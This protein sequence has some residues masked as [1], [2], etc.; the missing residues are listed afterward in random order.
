MKK[1]KHVERVLEVEGLD[2]QIKEIK[3]GSVDADTP[4]VKVPD[5]KDIDFDLKPTVQ[6]PVIKGEAQVEVQKPDAQIEVD[7]PDVHIVNPEIDLAK[8]SR[9]R[10]SSSSSSSSDEEDEKKKDKDKKKKKKDKKEK[11]DKDKKEKK[12]GF[13]GLFGRKSRSPS[14]KKETK[15]KDKKKKDKK[16]GSKESTPDRRSTS[17]EGSVEVK[18]PLP[19]GEV[20]FPEERK[21][22]GFEVTLPHLKLPSLHTAVNPEGDAELEDVSLESPKG[23]L[24][25]EAKVKAKAPDPNLVIVT[26]EIVT[27]EGK[28]KES[29]LER[30]KKRGFFSL[31]RGEKKD[32]DNK[33]KSSID[34]E[35]SDK[36]DRSR[37]SLNVELE[38]DLPEEGKIDADVKLKADRKRKSSTGSETSDPEKEKKHRTGF[39][40]HFPKFGGK[41]KGE[42]ETEGPK[43]GF[44]VEDLE[45]VEVKAPKV[46]TEKKRKSSVSSDTS[47]TEKEKK[48][49]GFDIHLPKAPKITLPKFGGKGEG[50]V[51]IDVDEPEVEVEV[52]KKRKSSVSSDTSDTDKEKKRKGF[53][54][55][56]PKVSL[57]KFGGK[58]K[59]EGDVEGPKEGY[60]VE[61]L[62]AVEVAAPKVKAEKQRKSSTSSET[63][64]TDKEGKRRGFDLHLPKAPKLE[65]PKFGGKGSVD[66]E[67][68]VDADKPKEGFVVEDL[69]S[70][71]VKAPKVEK[72]RTTSTSS[73]T[74]DTDKEGKRR[75]FDI[76]LPKVSLPKF[77]G[78]GKVEAE[79]DEPE[80]EVEVEKKRKSS[81]SS[82]TSDTDKEK[83]KGFDIHLPNVH[84]PK[85]GGK[86]K[87]E[88]DI[89]GPKE[90]FVIEDLEAVEVKAPKVKADRK[91]SVSSDTSDTDRE[92]RKGFDLHLPKAPKINL[93]KFGGK[94]KVEGDI[95]VD[96]DVP[97]VEVEVEKKRKSS[98]SS[99]TGDTDK[100]KKRKGFDIHLPKVSL[101]KF[102]GKAKVDGEVD[103]PSEGFVVEDLESIEVKKPK[104]KRK[105]STGSDPDK[106]EVELEAPSVSVEKKS[107]SLDRKTPKKK[108]FGGFTFG[109]KTP[110]VKRKSSVSSTS[111]DEGKTPKGPKEGF[112]IEDVVAV[113]GS[114]GKKHK[115]KKPELDVEVEGP[116]LSVESKSSSLDKKS[117][118]TKKK[119]FGGFS[120]GR[121]K[122][123]S[124]ETTPEPKRKG[125]TSSQTSEDDKD[126]KSRGFGIQLPKFGGKAKVEGDVEGPKE[127][128]VVEDLEAV[129]V[130]APKVKAEKQRKSSASSET[131]D[132]DKEKKHR[133]FDIHLPKVSLPK[134]GGKGKVEGD[135]DGELDIDVDKPEVEVEKK[136]KSSVSSDTSDTDREKRKGFDLHLPKAPKIN[137]P[138]FEGKAKVEGDAEGPKE[139]YVI[140]DLEAVEVKAP[141][142]KAERK[143]SVSSD[144]SDTEKEKKHRGFDIH[145]PK[146]SLPKFGGK[147]KVEGDVNVDVDAPEVEVEIEKKRK[148]SVSS[149]TSDT[150]KEKKHRGFD[151]HL[152]KVS[153]PKFGGKGGIEGE[154]DGPKEGFVVEDLEA[155]EVKAPKV[156]AER[157]SSVSSD[158]SDTDREKRKRIRPPP[159]QSTKCKLAQIWRQRKSRR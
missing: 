101:P 30:K 77:G 31:G 144:T 100:E 44:V 105:T 8:R 53:D 79:V 21:H 110:E 29:T 76:H 51:D 47:D 156:K 45:S 86:G 19:E 115:K 102:G 26:G 142:V 33:R 13:F 17:R 81:V 61:N 74:S 15:D 55:H 14:P 27:E 126:K 99:D 139:G 36:S 158:T 89:E 82:D 25:R 133:G 37:P 56:L 150:D 91:S 73:E 135:V 107:A 109:K 121:K 108:L 112:V 143:S 152:P 145:L 32:K 18:A 127:G 12:G 141:K 35:K 69:E 38:G 128:F 94:G 148:S 28:S 75:G 11:K 68:D 5:V 120:L 137:L 80:V 131:S 60:V 16:R 24:E 111:D 46:K 41:D 49:R 122:K 48:R 66:G 3:L 117:P 1:V 146:V 119:L 114:S 125:S 63:S 34:S 149:D 155:V 87:V 140:E 103:G 90:G 136:R 134:F 84:L 116:S 159:P 132:T 138:K 85:F 59:V 92:K 71:E 88:G 98:V 6:V 65:L 147:G 78:K 40:I 67:V 52:E 42:G 151:I 118:R 83:R 57:P 58:A 39:G 153:L 22:T 2:G 129:E 124:E 96:V 9:S 43:E 62:E 106:L 54:I 72:Q 130:K 93:P 4:E 123:G 104:V 95:D 157:K 20:K 23:T 7:K 64:D 154:V 10:S 70:V 97:E 50:E 113:E